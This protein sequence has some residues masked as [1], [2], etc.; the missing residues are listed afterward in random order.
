MKK[1][2]FEFY[3]KEE[4]IK[5]FNEQI[6]KLKYKIIKEKCCILFD[7]FSFNKCFVLLEYW[8]SEDDFF[9]QPSENHL[10]IFRENVK[11]YILSTRKKYNIIEEIF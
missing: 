2:L 11:N 1:L 3:V 9:N 6:I 10:I 8:V 4:H 7:Y 5:R